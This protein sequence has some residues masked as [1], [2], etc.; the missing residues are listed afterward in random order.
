M[1]LKIKDFEALCTKCGYVVQSNVTPVISYIIFTIG[2]L[3]AFQWHPKEKM[4]NF[5]SVI[6]QWASTLSY[7]E[8]QNC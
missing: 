2:T 4:G 5:G 7:Q 8:E 1:N 3:T 6:L